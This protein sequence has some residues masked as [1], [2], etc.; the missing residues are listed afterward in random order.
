MC[1]KSSWGLRYVFK[2]I[3]KDNMYQNM[4]PEEWGSI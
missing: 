2:E 4:T 3:Q 1:L